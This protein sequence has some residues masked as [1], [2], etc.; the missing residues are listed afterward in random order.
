MQYHQDAKRIRSEVPPCCQK[1][2]Y[3]TC[4][5]FLPVDQ[6]SC[7]KLLQG[8]VAAVGAG[9]S[10]PFPWICVEPGSAAPKAIPPA[11]QL[12]G[13]LLTPS[14][15]T[16]QTGA[17]GCL[18]MLCC[19]YVLRGLMVRRGSGDLHGERARRDLERVGSI[20]GNGVVP[21]VSLVCHKNN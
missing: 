20:R 2:N 18:L 5:L 1:H 19:S 8:G 16:W 7:W 13:G 4:K 21:E 17:Y 11:Q 14:L 15:P 6:R 9:V 12:P 10:L 3:C